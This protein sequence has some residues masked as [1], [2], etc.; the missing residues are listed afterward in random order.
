MHMLM[1]CEGGHSS[2]SLVQSSQYDEVFILFG[3]ERLSLS[4]C[5]AWRRHR[6][7]DSSRYMKL[8]IPMT[9]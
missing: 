4:T 8:K 2:L 1:D 6:D 5:V 9:I 3:Q 7:G